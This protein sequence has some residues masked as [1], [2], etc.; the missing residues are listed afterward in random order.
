MRTKNRDSR[1]AS[2]LGRLAVL[3]FAVGACVSQAQTVYRCEVRGK[4][5]YSHE[6]CLGARPIDTTPTQGLDKSSGVSRKGADVRREEFNKSFG[7]A[8]RP[9]TGM[10][11]EQRAIM[12]RR[13]KLSH[14]EKLECTWLDS[15]LE[16]L[17]ADERNASAQNLPAAQLALFDTRKRYRELRC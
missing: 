16:S 9:I 15:R 13:F 10:D 7:D 12:H 6:P 8:I 3:V 17:Q 5:A 4:V 1:R 11:D 14:A 2:T